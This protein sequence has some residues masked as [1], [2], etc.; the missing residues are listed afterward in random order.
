M[1]A[2]RPKCRIH[3]VFLVS[4][5]ELRPPLDSERPML[6]PG[7]NKVQDAICPEF[8][9]GEV[10]LIQYVQLDDPVRDEA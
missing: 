5:S 7:T 6:E 2:K 1:K 8:G 4:E 9:C 10:G 3:G